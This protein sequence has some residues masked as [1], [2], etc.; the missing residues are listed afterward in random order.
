M[1]SIGK[2]AQVALEFFALAG[3]LALFLLLVTMASW[4]RRNDVEREQLGY[5]GESVCYQLR[6][7][8]NAANAIGDGY[9][10]RFS[11]PQML[12]GSFVY[13][14]DKSYLSQERSL[15]VRWNGG[16]CSA[17][18]LPSSF[19]GESALVPGADVIVK[20]VGGVITFE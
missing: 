17:V 19:A 6:S 14:I 12:L 13:E 3:M 4:Q 16:A 20:N 15:V 7:E 1:G 11:L 18:L 5:S 2:K 10:R 9:A 8:I